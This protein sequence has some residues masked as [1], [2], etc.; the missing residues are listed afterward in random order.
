MSRPGNRR[1]CW[2]S[3]RARGV[4]G[5][6][7]K[8]NKGQTTA[9]CRTHFA[10]GRESQRKAPVGG[11]QKT[12]LGQ[13]VIPG[14]LSGE[15]KV[16]ERISGPWPRRCRPARGKLRCK[17]KR[18]VCRRR[19]LTGAC[20]TSGAAANA[21][22]QPCRSRVGKQRGGVHA[23]TAVVRDREAFRS[24]RRLAPMGKGIRDAVLFLYATSLSYEDAPLGWYSALWVRVSAPGDWDALV[25]RDRALRWVLV[26]A[27][28]P[29]GKPAT[30]QPGW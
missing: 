2:Q 14:K 11:W 19:R 5:V 6:I 16:E 7:H 1:A 17:G 9:L 25:K 26:P 24:L 15:G 22:Q 29:R 13:G 18:P 21:V 10:H 3:A 4:S 23:P 30:P 12:Q 27:G 20:K 28:A 8:R